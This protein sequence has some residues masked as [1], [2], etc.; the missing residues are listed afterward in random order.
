MRVRVLQARTGR[1]RNVVAGYAPAWSAGGR[2]IAFVRDDRIAILA[3]PTGRVSYVGR[4]PPATYIRSPS[5]SPDGRRLAVVTGG[6]RI[7]VVTV[8]T[9]ASRLLGLGR[10]PSWSRDGQWIAVACLYSSRAAFFAPNRSNEGCADHAIHM[11][12]HQPRWSPRGRQVAFSACF[13]PGPD[14]GIRLQRRGAALAHRI[15]RFGI[16]PSWSRDGRRLVFS[17]GREDA[18]LF[19]ANADGSGVRPLPLRP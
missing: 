8:A 19:L 4:R 2:R 10:T 17:S 6:N 9:G 1:T 18:R 16:Y 5:W 13:D 14:C 11:T 3:V 7:A 12:A 15:T